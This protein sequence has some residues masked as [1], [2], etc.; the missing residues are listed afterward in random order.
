MTS[1]AKIPTEDAYAIFE[2]I[3]EINGYAAVTTG[4]ITKIIPDKN[5][6][7]KNSETMSCPFSS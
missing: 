3:L 7:E 1:P 4:N 2:S 6:G 5:A